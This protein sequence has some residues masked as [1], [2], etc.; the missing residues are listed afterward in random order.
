M[1]ATECSKPRAIKVE[2]GN[3][4]APNLPIIV[5]LAIAPHTPRHTSQLQRIP[6]ARATENGR[7]A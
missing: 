5:L 1:F 6:F 3:Q 2:I 4:I 7:V